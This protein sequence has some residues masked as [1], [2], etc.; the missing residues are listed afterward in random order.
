MTGLPEFRRKDRHH[1]HVPALAFRAN[2]IA[3]PGD[4]NED[5]VIRQL[6]I[7]EGQLRSMAAARALTVDGE[8]GFARRFCVAYRLRRLAARHVTGLPH[9]GS[10]FIAEH[11]RTR[12][13]KGFG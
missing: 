5:R 7:R 4:V 11:P 1:L 13:F 3:Q 2:E 6:Q 10:H 9:R 8:P 12:T